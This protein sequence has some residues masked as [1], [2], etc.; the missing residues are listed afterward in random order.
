FNKSDGHLPGRCN[1][2]LRAALMRGG[3]CLQNC[4]PY[5]RALAASWRKAGVDARAIHIKVTLRLCRILWHIVAEDSVFCHPKTTTRHYILDKLLSFHR[6]HASPAD[7]I[8][9]DLEAARAQL[10]QTEYKAEAD[11]LEQ[12]RDA[13]P[14]GRGAKARQLVDIL[15]KVLTRLG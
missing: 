2:S 3:D 15:P 11:I 12:R 10:P 14:L 8:L 5:F 13:L 9:R 7:V 6:A 4:H 1:R